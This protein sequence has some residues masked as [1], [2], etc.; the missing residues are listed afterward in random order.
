M[1][2]YCAD[3]IAMNPIEKAGPASAAGRAAAAAVT[4]AVEN[5]NKNIGRRSGNKVDV[6][7]T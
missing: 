7:R 5:T 1:V 6:T 3:A 2:G 4:A